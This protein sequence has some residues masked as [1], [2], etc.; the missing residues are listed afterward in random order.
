VPKKSFSLS[1]VPDFDDAPSVVLITGPVEFFVEEAAAQAAQKLAAAGAELLEF[2]SDTPSEAISDALLN[3][4]LFSPR[5][6][7]RWDVS[8]VLGSEPPVVLLAAAIEAWNRGPGGRREAFR[9][10]RALLSALEVAS[11]A[12]PDE[13]AVAVARKVRR[14]DDATALAEILR[15]LPDEKGGPAVFREALKVL[16][17]R[18]NEG[19]V[20]LLTASGA[21]SLGDLVGEIER[22]GLQLTLSDSRSSDESLAR[23][24]RERARERE[25]TLDADAI[26]RLRL[27]TDGQPEAFATELDKLLQW[28]GPGG[29]VRAADV[30]DNVSDESSEDLYAF[31]DAVGRRDSADALGRLERL[32][33]G[34]VVRAAAREIDTDNYWPVYFLGMLAGEVRRMLLFRSKLEDGSVPEFDAAMSPRTFEARLLPSLVEPI[35]PFGHSP[36]RS[37][38]PY[39]WFKVAQRAARYETKELAR[40]LARAADADVRLKTSGAP[41]EI[42]SAY[43]GELIAGA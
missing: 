42:L 16:L 32:F 26:Q 11:G 39:L 30:A 19:T 37:G 22:K 1:A 18:P 3:R 6:V 12:D 28:A 2:D 29:R 27:S 33:S 21:G 43:V 4:S 23:L 24:A 14:R 17:E 10:V 8:R 38:P 34:R 35:S 36:F 13:L 40:A 15:D 9:K 41:L 5:R 7:V 31:Y 25:V 20:A